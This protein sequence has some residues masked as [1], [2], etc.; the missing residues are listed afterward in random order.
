M[1]KQPS[2]NDQLSKL[3][4]I[5]DWFEKQQEVDVEQGLD[6][7]K[8]GAELIRELKSRLKKVEN[9]FKEIREGLEESEE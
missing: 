4:T 1:T 7:V 2:I 5:V 3:Q 8:E 6:K 9:E